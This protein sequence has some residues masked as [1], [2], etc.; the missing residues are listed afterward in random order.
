MISFSDA[1]RAISVQL[2]KEEEE[3][4]RKERIRIFNLLA[5]K[6]KTDEAKALQDFKEERLQ[7]EEDRLIKKYEARAK[8]DKAAVVFSYDDPVIMR[9]EQAIGKIKEE[10]TAFRNRICEEK[11]VNKNL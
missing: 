7:K 6:Q 2:V 11:T 10:Q 5:A 9:L 1:S 3:E 8:E 4:E